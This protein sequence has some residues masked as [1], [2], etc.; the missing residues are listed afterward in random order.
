MLANKP[1][2]LLRLERAASRRRRV[3]H[4]PLPAV[5]GLA[6]RGPMEPF[7]SLI[8]AKQAPE[9]RPAGFGVASG[10]RPRADPG[11]VKPGLRSTER[12]HESSIR[13]RGSG[14]A[15]D[16][17][18]RGWRYRR[19]ERL[20]G[21]GGEAV[22]AEGHAAAE[23]V[24]RAVALTYEVDTPAGPVVHCHCGTGRKAHGSVFSSIM[25]VPR[26]SFRWTRGES[27]LARFESSPGKFRCFSSKCGSLLTADISLGAAPIRPRSAG[28]PPGCAIF[29]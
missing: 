28:N 12:R 24:G 6:Q 7:A 4:R 20:R 22:D 15:A 17:G 3:G 5:R 27:L 19:R 29:R 9:R 23:R 8:S 21:P 14:V 26:D 18:G 10:P 16:F 1:G 13:Q 11:L 2:H 25:A